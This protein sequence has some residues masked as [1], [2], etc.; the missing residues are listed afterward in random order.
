MHNPDD[1]DFFEKTSIALYSPSMMNPDLAPKDRSSLMLQTF[2]PSGWMRNWGG[3][4]KE[5]YT[6]L[7]EKV[8]K[9]LLRKAEAIVPNLGSL[10]EF[11]DAAT[12]LTYER[13]T[14]NTDGATSAWSWN[15]KRRFF[16]QMM[17]SNIE[18]PVKNL[19]IG[20]CWANQIGGVPG[21]LAAAY[22]CSMKIK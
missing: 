4:S 20:S 14:H 6:D 15:P 9:T 5:R 10:V 16:T 22:L 21:A 7:K 1:E 3:E 18:T 19:Y 12:P 13:Y 17:R 8:R 2:S 11:E